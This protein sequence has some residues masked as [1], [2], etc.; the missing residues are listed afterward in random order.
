MCNFNQL[1]IPSNLKHDYRCFRLFPELG[2]NISGEKLQVKFRFNILVFF[3]KISEI[4]YN[5]EFSI[6]CM[7]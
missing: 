7:E 4:E 6:D 1:H 3:N 5:T 2:Y